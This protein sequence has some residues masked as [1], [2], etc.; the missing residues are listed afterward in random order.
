M[1]ESTKNNLE[2]EIFLAVV[3]VSNSD[4]MALEKAAALM[5]LIPIMRTYRKAGF[6]ED[7]LIRP[8]IWKKIAFINEAVSVS[9]LKDILKLPKVRYDGCKIRPVG[10]YAIPEEELIMWSETSLRGPLI[11]EAYKR[12]AELFQQVFPDKRSMIG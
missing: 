9:Q 12:Y 7:A 4:K 1:S 3:E 6:L 10:E 2:L 8:I 11:S 5:A